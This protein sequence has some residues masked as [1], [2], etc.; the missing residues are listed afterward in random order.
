MYAKRETKMIQHIDTLT[1]IKVVGKLN[2]F[3]NNAR[4][5]TFV[6]LLYRRN[7]VSFAEIIYHPLCRLALY[8]CAA[9]IRSG[10]EGCDDLTFI[11]G[12]R[13]LARKQTAKI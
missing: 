13:P 4:A 6:S 3:S 2:V 8:L 12:F 10:P 9:A 5:Y 7:D 11:T 1:A